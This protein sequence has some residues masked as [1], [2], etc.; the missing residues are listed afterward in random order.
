MKLINFFIDELGNANPKDTKSNLYILSGIMVTN[1]NREELKIKADQIK[2]KYW[3]RTNIVFHSREIGRSEG[4]FQILKDPKIKENFEKDLTK[5]LNLSLFQLFAVVVDKQKI[6]KNWIDKTIYKRTAD[7]LIKNFILS[8][9]A[10]K[11]CKG[12]LVVESATAEKDFFY[13]KAAGYYLS[14][15]FRELKINFKE[16]QDVLT[17]ISFV[18]KKNEDIEEQIADLLAYGIR[19]KYEN[20]KLFQLPSYEKELVKTVNSKLFKINPNTGITKKKLYSQ[21]ESFQIIPQIN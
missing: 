7:N 9:L 15:G 19:I 2:F 6:P 20:K 8:L 5:F 13:H 11:N 3:S 14:N 17:E 4:E 12:R 1:Q 18:S 21:I 16:V 10:Q